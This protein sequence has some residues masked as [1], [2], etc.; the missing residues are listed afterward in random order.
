MTNAPTK[1]NGT[2]VEFLRLLV[3]YR[4]RNCVTWPFKRL[5]NGYGQFHFNGE[6]LYSH[7]YM[8]ELAKG[9][10]PTENH[11]VA[12]ECGKGHLGCVNPQHLSWKTR[13]ENELDKRQHGTTRNAWWAHKGKLTPVQVE[14]IRALKGQRTQAEIAALFSI[15]EP[16]IRDIF[17]GRSWKP[18]PKV[19]GY[20]ENEDGEIKSTVAAGADLEALA[21]RLGRSLGSVRS[22]AYR[23]GAL[24]NRN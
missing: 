6:Q 4:G 18:N 13:T 11:I 9:P 20:R 24:G 5:P 3:G 1:G 2:G 23:I 22:R 15:S 19:R 10:P 17:L 21:T 7:R 8:C 12:H 16:T 14:E